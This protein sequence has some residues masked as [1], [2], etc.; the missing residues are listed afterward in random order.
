MFTGAEVAAFADWL[1]R[2]HDSLCEIERIKLPIPSD[3]YPIGAIPSGGGSDFYE[4]HRHSEY[5]LPFAV[6]G[7]FNSRHPLTKD[8]LRLVWARQVTKVI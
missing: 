6:A 4:V 3:A 8:E 7:F 1:L 5:D 2:T